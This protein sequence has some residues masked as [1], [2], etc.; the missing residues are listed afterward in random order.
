MSGELSRPEIT[1]SGKRA[2][3]TSVE[4]PGPHPRSTI[5]RASISGNADNRSRTG[6][7]RSSSKAR[8]CLAD[9][10][11]FSLRMEVGR[12]WYQ[13]HP[14]TAHMWCN[15]LEIKGKHPSFGRDFSAAFSYNDWI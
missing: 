11:I 4:L 8:Y 2:A 14:G 12:G 9:Q 10:L 5:A 6:R 1:A 15:C 3:K 13:S 7:V